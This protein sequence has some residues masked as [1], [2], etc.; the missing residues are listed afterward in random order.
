MGYGGLPLRQRICSLILT[1]VAALILFGMP[2]GVL[3][4]QTSTPM[5]SPVCANAVNNTM[6]V[7]GGVSCRLREGARTASD[8]QM[9]ACQAQQ[10]VQLL[11]SSIESHQADIAYRNDELRELYLRS[12]TG[13]WTARVWRLLVYSMA[14]SYRQIESVGDYWRIGTLESSLLIEYSKIGASRSSRTSGNDRVDCQ[15]VSELLAGTSL[16]SVVDSEF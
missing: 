15:P 7:T 1:A 16:S 14:W 2:A 13:H 10:A 4:Q 11:V 12:T 6:T 8:K 3:A 9:R 5:H